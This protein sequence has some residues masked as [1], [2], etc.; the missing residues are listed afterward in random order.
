MSDVLDKHLE[1]TKV[2]NSS[3]PENSKESDDELKDTHDETLDETLDPS[4]DDTL[5]ENV[6]NVTDCL[7]IILN[8]GTHAGE[9]PYICEISRMQESFLHPRYS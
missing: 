7:Q 1:D 4:L 9:K 2:F 3:V 8:Q 5:D 6:P